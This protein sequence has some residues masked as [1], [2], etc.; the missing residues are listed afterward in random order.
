MVVY[1]TILPEVV[2][3]GTALFLVLLGFVTQRRPGI[4]WGIAMGA[5]LF[6][7]FLTIDMMFASVRPGG[8]LLALFGLDLYEAGGATL[9]VQRFADL[10]LAKDLFSLFFHLVFLLVAFLAIL[11]SRSYVKKEEPHQAEYYALLFL[12]VVGMMFVAEATDLFVL[13][14]AFELSTLSTFALVAFRK[15]DA[16]ATEAAAKFFVIGAVS[17]AIILFGISL[18]YGVTGAATGTPTTDLWMTS[19][20]GVLTSP[21]STAMAVGSAQGYGPTIVIAI[22]FLIAGFGFKVATVPFHQWAPDVYEGSPDTIT[23]FLAAGTKKVGV[24]AFFKVFLVGLAG[25]TGDWIF[26]LALVAIITQTVGNVLAIP[27][28]SVKRMLAYSSIAQAGY[29]LTAIIVATVAYDASRG[30][31]VTGPARAEDSKR[32]EIATYAIAGGLY[33][34][35]THAIMKGGAFLAVSAASAHVGDRIE[36]FKGLARKMPF[37]AVALSIFLLSLAGIPF[38]GGFFSKF[39]L[40]SSAV[41]AT[42]YNGWM[43]WLAVSGVLNSALSLYY[44][45]RVIRFMVIEEEKPARLPVPAPM[46]LAIGLALFGIIITG[47]LA[48]PFFGAAQ[49]AGRAFLP[50]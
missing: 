32:W 36:D 40:F 9:G 8:S 15:K 29:I 23:V 46:L 5:L 4:L 7:S 13:F 37:V 1:A 19:T 18:I 50:R 41:Y 2:L 17:S 28:R 25:V 31:F 14:L 16:R 3:I 24:L 34:I 49:E 47:L 20:N 6:A 38:F 27:Q 35:L 45:A 30:G 33:H 10:H 48:W 43:L 12:S 42:Q 39:V 26:A 22:V 21:M 11:A 44:Y